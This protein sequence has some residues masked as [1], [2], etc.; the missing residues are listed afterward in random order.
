M[1]RWQKNVKTH[2]ML[3]VECYSQEGRRKRRERGGEQGE[4]R[5]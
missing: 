1:G 5:E 3:M 4:E 2:D